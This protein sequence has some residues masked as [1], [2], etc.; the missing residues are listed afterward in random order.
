MIVSEDVNI[1]IDLD[2]VN[3][4]IDLDDV[5][6][7]GAVNDGMLMNE[8]YILDRDKSRQTNFLNPN[9]NT[10]TKAEFKPDLTKDIPSFALDWDSFREVSQC[11]CGKPIDFISRKVH[12]F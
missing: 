11:S 1:K 12:I 10:L 8:R 2:D 9:T 3:I 5:N 6:V 7:T 4:K